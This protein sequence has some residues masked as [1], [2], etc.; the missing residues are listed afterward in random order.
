MLPR[1]T[2]VASGVSCLGPWGRTQTNAYLV[3][4]GDARV[5]IDAGWASDVAR[6]EQAVQALLGETVR[7][8]AIVLTHCHPDHAGA[9]GQLASRWRCPVWMHPDEWPIA[10]GDFAAM[11]RWAG[12]LDRW[13]V[14]PIM[15]AMGTRRREA[16]LARSSLADVARTFSPDDEVPGLPDWE[17]VPTPGHTPGHISFLRRPDGV[18]ITGDALVTLRVNSVSG[19][20]LQR[21]GP[22]GPPWYT[23]WSRQAAVASIT[24][25]AEL[26]PTTIAPGHGLP[27][28]G[29]AAAAA[30]RAL[31][32][33]DA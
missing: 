17:C 12:P 9:A 14:L 8:D 16:A 32:P 19:L 30:F 11:Q 25:I 4:S 33:S 13:V 27:M 31:L 20:V 29:A 5:L 28:T 23:T 24:R 26:R 21:R 1:I 15:R 6:I 7:P 10:T 22:S 3:R 18:V 2:T